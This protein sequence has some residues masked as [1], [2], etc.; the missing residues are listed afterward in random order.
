MAQAF[1]LSAVAR[2]DL[3]DRFLSLRRFAAVKNPAQLPAGAEYRRLKC[4][5]NTAD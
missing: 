3:K 4:N 5:Q 1:A 2:A